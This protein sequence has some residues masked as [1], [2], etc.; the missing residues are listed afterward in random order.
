[1]KKAPQKIDTVNSSQ[2]SLGTNLLTTFCNPFVLLHPHK[3]GAKQSAQS[4]AEHEVPYLNR[5]SIHLILP[6]GIKYSNGINEK[7]P[8]HIDKQ[9]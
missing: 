8:V 2:F 7:P 5:R 9:K 1:M 4:Q 3:P 6:G